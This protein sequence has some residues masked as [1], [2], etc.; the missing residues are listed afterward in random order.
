MYIS[1]NSAYLKYHPN[2]IPASIY[3][4]SKKYIIMINIYFFLEC[5]VHVIVNLDFNE[6]INFV[7]K[8]SDYF[9][10]SFNHTFCVHN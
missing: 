8:N 10:L 2:R 6:T 1:T 3:K 4:M 9:D 5:F 7:D